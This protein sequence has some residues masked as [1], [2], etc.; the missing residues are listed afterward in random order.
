ML[1][2][3]GVCCIDEFD[4]MGSEQVPQL[5]IQKDTSSIHRLLNIR[6]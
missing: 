5:L 6:Q 3:Q 4:K 2:D 1:S